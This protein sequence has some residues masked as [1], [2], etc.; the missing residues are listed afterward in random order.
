MEKLLAWFMNQ[1]DDNE[2]NEDRSTVVSL[3]A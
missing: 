3:V 2:D 1:S